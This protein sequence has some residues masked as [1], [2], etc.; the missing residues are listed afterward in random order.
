MSPVINALSV[1][2]MAASVVLAFST[3]GV[4]KYVG[5]G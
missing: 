5:K 3:R 4:V 1:M 2:L